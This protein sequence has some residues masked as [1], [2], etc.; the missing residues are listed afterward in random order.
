MVAGLSVHGVEEGR[1]LPTIQP[2]DLLRVAL[3]FAEEFAARQTITLCCGA[4][5]CASSSTLSSRLRV[6]G[7]LKRS[8]IR[9]TTSSI[10]GL[11]RRLTM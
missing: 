9:P 4:Y 7:R 11:R 8:A 3:S 6:L 5:D 10:A 1:Q 2:F